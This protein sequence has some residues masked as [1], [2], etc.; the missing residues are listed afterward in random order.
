MVQPG[1]LNI[2]F[3]RFIFYCADPDIPMVIG[4]SIHSLR[5]LDSIHEFRT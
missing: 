2:A 3:S 1:H 5:R 4:A